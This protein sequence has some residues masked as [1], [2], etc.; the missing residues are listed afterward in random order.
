M[1]SSSSSSPKS[2][3][4]AV[5]ASYRV[6][7][8]W[9]VE[10]DITAPAFHLEKPIN[11]VPLAGDWSVEITKNTMLKAGVNYGNKLPAG[12]LGSAVVSRLALYWVDSDGVGHPLV[13]DRYEDPLPD[14]ALDGG[15]YA[16]EILDVEKEDWERH[17]AKSNGAYVPSSHRAYRL[18]VHLE[19]SYTDPVESARSGAQ[20][21]ARLNL[22]QVPHDV[23]LFFPSPRPGGAE[24]WAKADILSEASAYFKD[25]LTSDFAESVPQRS[26][27]ARIEAVVKVDAAPNGP[28]KDFADSDDETDE[29][30]F[31]KRPPNVDASPAADDLPYRQ[32]AITQTA[33]ST[34]YAIL[35]FLH[36]D[37]IHFAPLRSSSSSPSFRRDAL[38]TSYTE[39][40]TLPLPISPKSAF[41]LADLLDLPTL[42]QRCLNAF[43]SAL[44]VRGVAHELFSDT[45]IA[46]DDLRAVVVDY[47]KENWE[48][49]R[50]SEGWKEHMERIKAGEAPEAAPLVVE[51]MEKLTGP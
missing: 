11:G 27:R 45:S 16:G 17:A 9:D 29:F 2:K 20:L 47:V 13:A 40:P 19:R 32:I 18:S 24:L 51:M 37:F 14:A 42:R 7:I 49:V 23:R 36:T 3:K 15:V 43:R 12:A 28:Q 4:V 30:F 39:R 34:Y 8:S 22:E 33:Y 44:T 31:S 41:R 1:S 21:A 5:D 25:L 26:K 46:Y 10:F 38:E 6:E 48:A 35:V 50:A